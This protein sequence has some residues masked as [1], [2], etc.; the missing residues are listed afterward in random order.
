MDAGLS[1][2]LWLR[3]RQEVSSLMPANGS[4]VLVLLS[5]AKGV[6]VLLSA[7]TLVLLLVDGSGAS[8]ES[9]RC[10]GVT[11]ALPPIMASI[12]YNTKSEG[13][14]DSSSDSRPTPL[15]LSVC[16]LLVLRLQ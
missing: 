13:T 5:K 4:D 12:S 2:R 14:S 6:Q 11:D 9:R 8:A 3:R 7:G 1:R 16:Y 15:L 10:V